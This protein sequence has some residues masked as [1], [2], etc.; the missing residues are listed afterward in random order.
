MCNVP[1][2]LWPQCRIHLDHFYKPGKKS[3]PQRCKPRQQ[4]WDQLFIHTETP[5][6]NNSY[7]PKLRGLI[8]QPP[9]IKTQSQREVGRLKEELDGDMGA[10][11]LLFKTDTSLV[12]APGGPAEN[13]ECRHT[14]TTTHPQHQQ[15]GHEGHC[16]SCQCP[17]QHTPG[18]TNSC[19][20]S[21]PATSQ[22]WRYTLSGVLLSKPIQPVIPNIK[23]FIT[24]NDNCL[25]LLCLLIVA[26]F[27]FRRAAA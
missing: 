14:E 1:D 3:L 21:V 12:S 23:R 11:L 26:S 13:K 22:C 19:V 9:T 6:G 4:V 25:T 5:P 17:P 20:T 2:V 16:H 10:F 27:A 18:Y 15:W 24:H 7:W 8:S